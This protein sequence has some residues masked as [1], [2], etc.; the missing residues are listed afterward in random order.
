MGFRLQKYDKVTKFS[1]TVRLSAQ[2]HNQKKHQKLEKRKN[3]L[4]A[5]IAC[6]P[7]EPIKLPIKR[8][9]PNIY[10]VLPP[11]QNKICFVFFS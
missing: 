2:M 8:N 1:V 9:L 6:F 4:S 10:E 7:L 11:L 3:I 5:R